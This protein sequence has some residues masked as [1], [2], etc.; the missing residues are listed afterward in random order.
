MPTTWYLGPAGSLV[1]L[2]PPLRDIARPLSR[3]AVQQV[4]LGGA[5][6]LDR[7]GRGRRSHTLAWSYLTPDEAAVLER[8]WQLPGE[9][10]LDDPSRRNRLTANQS[11]GGDTGRTAD[12]CIARFQGTVS[13]STAQARSGARSFAWATGTAL[14]VTNRGL[15]LYNGPSPEPVDDTWHPVRP[16]AFYAHAGYLRSTAAV[17]MYGGWDW[18]DAAGAYLSTS[19]IGTS[20]ALSTSNF[21]TR[22]ERTGVAAPAGAAYGIPFYL[23]ATTTGAAITVYL[24]EPQVE[25]VTAAGVSCGA[26]VIGSGV[27]RVATTGELPQTTPLAGWENL[28][29]ALVEL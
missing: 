16:G 22:V 27:P 20:T 17:S 15:Y 21:S 13:V 2:P 28:E 18:H 12:G 25:E 1:A 4:A 3:P 8:L 23:N 29:L 6:T 19:A 9:L 7:M 5:V 26:Y 14:A 11:T 10:I 24:D